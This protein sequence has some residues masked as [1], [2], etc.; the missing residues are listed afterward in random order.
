M[1]A[2]LAFEYT[3]VYK[4]CSTLIVFLRSQKMSCFLVQE[5][6]GVKCKSSS[7]REK[8]GFWSEMQIFCAGAIVMINLI[9]FLL[10][11][12]VKTFKENSFQNLLLVSL[13]YPRNF[14]TWSTTR[15][16]SVCDSISV[17]N[18]NRTFVSRK[19]LSPSNVRGRDGDPD[20]VLQNA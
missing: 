8:K 12:Y 1:R 4:A 18:N 15:K 14:I 3:S 6:R 5:P 9:F 2:V 19:A 11:M 16:E 10:Y 20:S 7:R 13:F 17:F